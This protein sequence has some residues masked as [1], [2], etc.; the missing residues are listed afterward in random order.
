MNNEILVKVAQFNKLALEEIES[1]NAKVASLEQDLETAHEFRSDKIEAV[2]KKAADALYEADF[3]T[4]RYSYR[5]FVKKA[6]ADPTVLVKTIEKICAYHDVASPGTPSSV[7]IKHADY[8]EKLG[9]DPIMERAFG[10]Q[11]LN[12]LDD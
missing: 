1:L 3:I 5:D 4:D 10:R 8:D 9:P 12:L 2:I 7:S 6:S 11:P